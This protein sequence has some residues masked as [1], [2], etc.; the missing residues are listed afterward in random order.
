MVLS[1]LLAAQL[2]NPAP[3]LSIPLLEQRIHDLI[4][5]Q[6]IEQKLKPLK[7]NER[8]STIARGHS[9]DMGSRGFFDHINPD[10]KNPTARAIAGKFPCKKELLDGNGGYTIGV[11]ENIF[12]KHLYRRVIYSP[13]GKT[14][15][16]W[17]SIND[18]AMTTVKG[19]MESQGHRANILNPRVDTSGLGIAAS[20]DD[21]VDIT[22]LYLL[23]NGTLL[24][25]PLLWRTHFN[26]ARRFRAKP[27]VYRGL[28]GVLQADK[29]PLRVSR[30]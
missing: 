19:W 9:A 30:E 28:R 8:L 1:L 11:S 23:S 26:G 25:V 22:Q 7:L 15:Y 16:D 12:H 18:I 2:A 5:T 4:N 17:N 21:K 6:R 3:E 24:S 29:N 27:D 14:T 13:A 20:A 10:G